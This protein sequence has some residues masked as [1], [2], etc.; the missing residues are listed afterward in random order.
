[1]LVAVSTRFHPPGQEWLGLHED[2]A[3]HFSGRFEDRDGPAAYAAVDLSSGTAHMRVRILP[4]PVTGSTVDGAL[5]DE[6]L[7]VVGDGSSGVF[8][9]RP[10]PTGYRGQVLCRLLYVDESVADAQTPTGYREE[11]LYEWKDRVRP[12]PGPSA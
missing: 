8:E 2:R 5:I 1:M 10:R 3:K 4:D 9:G 11:V 12:S 6:E 7:P